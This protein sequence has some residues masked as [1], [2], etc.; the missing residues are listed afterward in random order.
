MLA[1]LVFLVTRWV[2]TTIDQ[3]NALVGTTLTRGKIPAAQQNVATGATVTMD[4][5]VG[6]AD[7]VTLEA[8]LA[9][10]AAAGDLGV[11]CFPY[12]A[13]GVTLLTTPLP[14]VANTGYPPTLAGGSCAAVQKYDVQGIDKVQFQ[15]KNN[16]AAT[17]TITASWRTESW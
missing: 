7:W 2:F 6:G 15:L 14:A 8:S 13:D 11:Q 10:A 5:P 4:A 16:N 9:G 3:Y 17:K 1:F 12:A